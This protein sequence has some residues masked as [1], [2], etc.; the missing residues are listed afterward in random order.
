MRA[1]NL[2]KIG[3]IE[4]EEVGKP[5]ISDGEVLV[6]VKAVGI[7][8]S[9]IPRIYQDGAHRMPLIP[10]HE[11][12]GKVVKTGKEEDKKWLG[13]R[14]GVFPLIPCRRCIACQKGKF[15]M[16][17]SYSYLGSRR[18]GGFAEYVAVPAENLIELPDNVTYEQAAMLEPMAVAVHAM[19]RLGFGKSNDGEGTAGSKT[20]TEYM[21]EVGK[22]KDVGYV[23]TAG[24]DDTIVVCG[25]G[26]IGT[27]LVMFLLELGIKNLYVI[28]NKDFQ[29][30]KMRALGV[31]ENH[32]C[33]SWT[34]DVKEW[35]SGVTDG[36]GVD[37]FFECVGRNETVSL[38]IDAAAPGGAVCLVG[39]PYTDMTLPKDVY[40]KIL[41]NQLRVMGTWNSSFFEWEAS[42]NSTQSQTEL[43]DWQYVLRLL[44][45]GRIAPEQFISH[46]FELD[47][48]EKGLHIMRDKSEDYM[49]VMIEI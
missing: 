39:N 40:W 5:Q 6:S 11:F 38:A 45:E 33:D 9:D 20:S 22:E 30:D 37:A 17:R 35:L 48:L 28:G 19:R 36:A 26:T 7:C 13:K 47:D 18:D 41:R 1:W 21:G 10:G 12:A 29:R 44:E 43:T 25:L 49:K 14:V 42:G 32:Y 16:C 46:R 2:K 24:G 3:M 31:P 4:Y 34:A 8:G 27:L 23:K 15:E